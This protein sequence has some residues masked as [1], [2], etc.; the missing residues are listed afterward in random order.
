MPF[1]AKKKII[2]PDI[3]IQEILKLELDI[4]DDVHHNVHMHIIGT[5]GYVPQI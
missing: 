2:S 5:E 4:Y 3:T 1:P